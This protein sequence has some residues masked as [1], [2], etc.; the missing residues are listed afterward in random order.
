ML[1]MIYSFHE[2]IHMLNIAQSIDSCNLQKSD[3]RNLL[4]AHDPISLQIT[5]EWNT[6]ANETMEHFRRAVEG[7]G[8]ALKGDRVGVY[9]NVYLEIDGKGKGRISALYEY[10]M[11]SHKNYTACYHQILTTTT[12]TGKTT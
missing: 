12:R 10:S 4:H 3:E 2:Y 5:Q 6:P 1:P 11:V 9:Q 7:G 8:R